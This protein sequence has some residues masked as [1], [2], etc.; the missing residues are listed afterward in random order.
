MLVFCVL[1]GHMLLFGHLHTILY[2][3]TLDNSLASKGT[4]M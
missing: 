3:V 4:L 2:Q 1:H